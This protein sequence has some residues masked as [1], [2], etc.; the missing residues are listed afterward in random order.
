MP[1]VYGS[2]APRKNKKVFWFLAAILALVLTH[3]LTMGILIIVWGHPVGVHA[4]VESGELRLYGVVVIAL[5]AMLCIW[6]QW[7]VTGGLLILLGGFVIIT[8][9]YSPVILFRVMQHPGQI[10]T[11]SVISA[12]LVSSAY[13]IAL[14]RS[15]RFKKGAVKGSS[16]WGKAKV[17][18][19]PTKGFILG[20]DHDGRLLRYD[21]DGH[22]MT[23]AATRSGKGIGTII[24]NLLSHPGSVI[25]TDPKGENYSVTSRWRSQLGPDH[26]VIAL[27]PFHLTEEGGSGYN[28]MDLID[29]SQPDHTEVARSMAE[30]MIGKPDKGEAHWVNEAKSALMAFILFA[31]SLPNPERHNLGTVRDLLSQPS[32]EF[33]KVLDGMSK[34]DVVAVKEGAARLDQ[35]DIKEFS[36][37]MSTIQAHTHIF[38][39]PPLR[40]TL[41]QTSFSQ[42]DILS[43][44]ASIYIIVPREHLESYAPW[45][46]TTLTSIYGLITRGAHKRTVKPKHRILFLLDEFANLG[47][48]PEILNAVSL[49]AGFGLSFWFILQDLSQLKEQYGEAWNSFLANS[50]VLQVFGIQDLYSSEQ[51]SRLLGE[52]TVWQ[53]TL[54]NRGED[55]VPKQTIDEQG[56][57]LLRVDEIRR[58]HPDRQIIISRPNQPVAATKIRYYDDKEFMHKAD[59]NPYVQ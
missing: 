1:G 40:A 21:R 35:K 24:P 29:L 14:V 10:Q 58:L 46:R 25:C 9:V 49:G 33:K 22:L 41:A 52:K 28:P 11:V 54:A 32:R 30:N 31:K 2:R 53:R 12:F 44:N 56:R 26:K 48:I 3:V 8:P 34:C 51:I 59:P 4:W 18:R 55:R 47:K 42:E 23:V 38:S 39:S 6:H 57:P 36:G 5:G 15:I 37:V 16:D 50:D 27:D 45:I 7:R 13:C 19:T 43:D 17:L 20:R